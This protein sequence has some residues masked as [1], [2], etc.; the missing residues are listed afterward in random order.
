MYLTK[1]EERMLDGEEG[2]AVQKAMQLLVALGD[3]LGAE[4][5]VEVES[6]QIAGISYGNIGEAGMEFLEDW[7]E[8]GARVRVKSTLNPAGMDI[9]RWRE[10]GVDEEYSERQ[11]RI[12]RAF[13]RMGVDITCTCTPYLVGNRPMAGSHIAWSESSAVGFA[14]S[15]LGA[16]TNRE[17]GP[18]ALAAAITGRTPLYGLHLD[19]NRLPT[20]M[21]KVEVRIKTAF[22]FSLLGYTVGR[23]LGSGIPYFSGIGRADTDRLKIMSA[24]LAASG[25]IAM[26]Y[27]GGKKRGEGG[28][29]R[30]CV[31]WRE[32]EASRSLLTG[33][34]NP[35]LACIGCPHC[36][37]QEMRDL[38]GALKGRR[39]KKGAGLWVWTSRGVYNQAEGMGYLRAIEGAGG[40]VFADTCMVVCPLEKSGYRHMVSNSCK[41]AHYVPSTSGLKASV[42][43]IYAALDFVT[44]AV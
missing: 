30:I 3:V 27:V 34:G 7:A 6:A 41:A 10:M 26:F 32:L 25:G 23:I 31:D 33:E 13:E 20:A 5:M 12:L 22:D 21:V 37:L 8:L 28:L 38:V 35:D 39:V 19:E 42:T 40:K 15:V 1:E 16:R 24:A 4:R 36:S 44:E 2:A 43:E 29:E 17:G 9:K 18:S 11:R 14:N